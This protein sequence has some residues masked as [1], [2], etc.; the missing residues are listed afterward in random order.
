MMRVHNHG[1]ECC[2]IKHI[3]GFPYFPKDKV[4]ALPMRKVHQGAGGE[5]RNPGK[6]FYPG[7]RPVEPAQTRLKALIDY[8]LSDKTGHLVEIVL[9][10]GTA[11]NWHEVLTKKGFRKVSVFH[12]S[13]TSGTEL[14]VYHLIIKGG[15]VL[16]VEEGEE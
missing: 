6:D 13:N 12:N 4:A 8:I 7:P 5:M 1:G 3:F 9:Y 15:K 11:A 10:K 2:G 14:H 16:K